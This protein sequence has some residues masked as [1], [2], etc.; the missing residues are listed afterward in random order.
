MSCL[1]ASTGRTGLAPLASHMPFALWSHAGQERHL[2]AN[3]SDGWEAKL[4]S[5]KEGVK[6]CSGKMLSVLVRQ[7]HPL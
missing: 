1:R 3:C 6:S 5:A 7:G 4:L 2:S